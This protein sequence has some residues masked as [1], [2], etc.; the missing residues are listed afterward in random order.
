MNFVVFIIIFIVMSILLFAYFN[1]QYPDMTYVKSMIDNKFYL[2]RNVQDKQNACDILAQLMEKILF[3]S[4][5]LKK[6][7]KNYPEYSEYINLLHT[8]AKDI[9]LIESTQNSAYTSYSVNKGEQI[10]FCLR[11]KNINNELHDINLI[12][13]V[14]LHEISH[15]ACPIY[16]N[17]GPLF[18]KIFSFLTEEAVK[19]NLYTKIDFAKNPTNYCGMMIS[20]G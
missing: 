11:T 19:L 7:E 2:V 15:V 18:K 12:M 14:V 6:N 16:D 8:K 13:Y 1:Y 4:N 5:Y 17:H 9:I 3:L 20:N 10:I